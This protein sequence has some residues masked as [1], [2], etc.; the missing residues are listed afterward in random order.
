MKIIYTDGGE[1][2]TAGVGHLRLVGERLRY[3]SIA[4]TKTHRGMIETFL[5]TI[6]PGDKEVEAV[7]SEGDSRQ[8]PNNSILL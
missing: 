2:S 3:L 1:T 8:K 7:V 5:G 4:I 6:P